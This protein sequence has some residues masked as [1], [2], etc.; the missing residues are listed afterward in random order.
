ME[1]GVRLLPASVSLVSSDD[2]WASSRSSLGDPPSEDLEEA[3]ESSEETSETETG[4]GRT[5]LSMIIPAA[6]L[7]VAGLAVTFWPHLGA[8][9]QAAAVRF[10]DQAGY[11]ATVLSGTRIAHPVAPFPTE[12][13]G[14]TAADVL[15]GAGSAVGGLILAFVALYWRRLPVLRRGFEPGSGLVR[16]IRRFQSGVV[17]DYVTWIVLGVAC[18]G[19]VLAFSIR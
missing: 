7:T 12:D 16:P 8:D 17:N 5:P 4:K 10:Q 6:V 9:V 18:L 19:G 11:N 2:S 1:S 15:S 13:T 3:E 14:I